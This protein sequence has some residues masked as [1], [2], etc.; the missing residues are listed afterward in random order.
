MAELNP[1]YRF[2]MGLFL[3]KSEA[4]KQH[5]QA[6]CH[7]YGIG[8]RSPEASE[9]DHWLSSSECADRFACKALCAWGPLDL[10]HCSF[11]CML[12][13]EF[14]GPLHAP[15]NQQADIAQLGER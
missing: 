3:Y 14:H 2:K 11:V 5:P 7:G 6:I 1:L 10:E 13:R 12:V 8:V 9:E 4:Q 15:Y